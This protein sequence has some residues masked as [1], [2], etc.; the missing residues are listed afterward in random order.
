MWY[1]AVPPSL[2]EG[3]I[4]AYSGHQLDSGIR[5]RPFMAKPWLGGPEAAG[6]PAFR[7]AASVSRE[8]LS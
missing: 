2:D 4:R 7:P 8:T 6:G 5:N 1:S 3:S